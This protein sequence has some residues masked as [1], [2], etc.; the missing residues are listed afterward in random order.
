M[1]ERLK[2]K[3][4]QE[5]NDEIPDEENEQSESYEETYRDGSAKNEC[6]RSDD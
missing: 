4:E 3:R 5:W 1:S 6:W 2:E